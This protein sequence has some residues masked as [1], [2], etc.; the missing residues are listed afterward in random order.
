MSAPVYREP[1]NPTADRAEKA[2]RLLLGQNDMPW[3]SRGAC[4]GEDPGIFWDPRVQE[5][6]AICGRCPVA[7]DCLEHAL[8]VSEPGGIWGGLTIRERRALQRGKPAVR[9]CAWCND[10]FHYMPARGRPSTYCSKACQNAA[11]YTQKRDSKERSGVKVGT[12]LERGHGLITRYRSGCRCSAC[13]RVA[14]MARAEYRR[15]S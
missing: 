2:K 7:Q 8:A 5:A 4:V 14:R 9:M 15:A 6:R 1:E 12:Y 13:K 10:E 3:R 11:Y